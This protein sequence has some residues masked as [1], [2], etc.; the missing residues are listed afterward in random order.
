VADSESIHSSNLLE[1]SIHL[2]LLA[3]SPQDENFRLTGFNDSSNYKKEKNQLELELANVAA[4]C[5][6]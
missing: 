2:G 4:I 5:S 3:W 6:W 1:L